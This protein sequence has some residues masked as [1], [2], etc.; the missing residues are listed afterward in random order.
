MRAPIDQTYKPRAGRKCTLLAFRVAA[1]IYCFHA[2]GYKLSDNILRSTVV[3]IPDKQ[4]ICT[5]FLTYMKQ[6]DKA[7]GSRAFGPDKTLSEKVQETLLMFV[8]F[9]IL[10]HNI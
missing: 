1:N 6:F 8:S 7:A 9:V 10:P 5:R 2:T 3:I 4:G